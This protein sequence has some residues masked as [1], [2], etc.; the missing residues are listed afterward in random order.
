MIT[1]TRLSGSALVINADLIERIDSTPRSVIT[2]VDGKKVVV[3]ES[4]AEIVH[5]TEVHRARVITL[6]DELTG[7]DGIGRPDAVCSPRPAL[8]PVPPM[9][10]GR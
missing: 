1:L 3:R 2:L 4:L 9:P 5:A 6:S 10:G 7:T 8:R